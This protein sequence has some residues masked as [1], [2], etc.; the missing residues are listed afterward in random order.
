MATK[1]E[2]CIHGKQ[3]MEEKIQACIDTLQLVYQD[4]RRGPDGDDAPHVTEV[5]RVINV[6][7]SVLHD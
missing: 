4:L 1:I 6:L 7:H 3:P 5:I 2:D